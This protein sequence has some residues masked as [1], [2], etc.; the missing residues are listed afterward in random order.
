MWV[1]FVGPTWSKIEPF[2]RHKDFPL[3]QYKKKFLSQLGWPYL[4]TYLWKLVCPTTQEA[5]LLI[6]HHDKLAAHSCHVKCFHKFLSTFGGTQFQD[7]IFVGEKSGVELNIIISSCWM[8]LGSQTLN[9][10]FF[11]GDSKFSMWM[12]NFMFPFG[13][14]I[15][16]L[17]L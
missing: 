9:E 12:I 4:L 8:F 7:P 3:N 15:E 6:T 16:C 1:Q 14:L 17:S 13:R 2:T 10:V 5:F 11:H